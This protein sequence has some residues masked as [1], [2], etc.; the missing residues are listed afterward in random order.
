MKLNLFYLLDSFHPPDVQLCQLPAW[1]L[2]F[3]IISSLLIIRAVYFTFKPTRRPPT[4]IT[5]RAWHLHLMDVL[6]PPDL[7]LSPSQLLLLEDLAA[8]FLQQGKSIGDADVPYAQA[9]LSSYFGYVRDATTKMASS[10][11]SPSNNPTTSLTPSRNTT[12]GNVKS[13]PRISSLGKTRHSQISSVGQTK[14]LRTTTPTVNKRKIMPIQSQKSVALSIL[15]STEAEAFIEDYN[16]DLDFENRKVQEMDNKIQKYTVDE[17]DA[18]TEGLGLI[19]GM[20]MKGAIPFK[21]ELA[22][23]RNHPTSIL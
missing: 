2:L 21:G 12:A 16:H 18:I 14:S 20:K 23:F 22:P 19:A 13:D 6:I 5:H 17:D 10:S 15:C 8:Q 7:S 4:F 9:L 1:L 11:S 3:M